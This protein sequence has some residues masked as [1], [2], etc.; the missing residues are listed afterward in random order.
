MVGDIPDQSIYIG[1]NFNTIS[2]DFY[3][4]DID[5]ADT[6][7]LWSTSGTSNL[8]VNI[9]N[10]VATINVINA[11]W[12][13]TETITFTA[14]DPGG[15]SASDSVTFTVLANQAPVV[16]NIPDQSVSVGQSFT[17][18]SLDDYVSDPDHTDLDIDWT[19]TGNWYLT[20][21][22]V[23]RGATITAP[24]DW[25]GSETI[26]FRATDPGLLWAED[27]ATFT[28]TAENDAPVVTDIPDQ[29]IAE[30]ANFE[31]INLDDY[32]SDVDNTDAEMIWSF[33]GNAELDV[34]ISTDRVATITAPVDWTGNE[35]ITFRATDPG[36]LW[37]EDT[38]TFKVE[39]LIEPPEDY[40]IFL[41]LI[42]R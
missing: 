25:I 42:L 28:V 38:A 33:T 27:T 11:E 20:V 22:I 12:T 41:P 8:S 16:S 19:F 3:V 35:T 9:V 1:Q 34:S 15:L 21:S 4:A 26:T 31:T 10:R 13:G 14:T 18:I 2:L 29:T 37:A 7:L 23:D 30:G 6:E 24:V 32:V 39:E 17:L 36:L 40:Y 5:N